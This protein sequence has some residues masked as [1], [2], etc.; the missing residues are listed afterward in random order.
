MIAMTTKL[1][2]KNQV[3]A[4]DLVDEIIMMNLDSDSYYALDPVGS[5]I[6]RL[7]EQPTSVAD[8]CNSLQEIF[9]V[10]SETCQKD[11]LPLLQQL[12]DE[13]LVRIVKA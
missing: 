12:L 11:T 6:W 5:H 8:L 10:D 2:Q 1:I 3:I 9:D 13:K 4:S 7:L